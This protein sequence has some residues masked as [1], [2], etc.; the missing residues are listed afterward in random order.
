MSS[1]ITST[2]RV[3]QGYPLS[4]TLFGLYIDEI[5]EFVERI[6]GPGAPLASILIPLLL[7]TDDIVLISDSAEGLQRHLDA[8]QEFCL[9]RDLTVNLGKTKVMVFNASQSWLESR[10]C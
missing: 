1:E 5:S 6:G 8:L 2:I 9:Q 4:P 7:Y 3:K 10:L